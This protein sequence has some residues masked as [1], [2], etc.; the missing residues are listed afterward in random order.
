VTQNGTAFCTNDKYCIDPLTNV[1]SECPLWT[2]Y[3]KTYY[4]IE[5]NKNNLTVSPEDEKLADF[6]D[7]PIHEKYA[8]LCHYFEK[9][10]SV[11]YRKAIP[12]ISSKEVISGRNNFI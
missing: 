1:T 12:G 4:D 6:I 8:Y 5:N 3:C 9:H 7:N 10:G 11:K 2:A